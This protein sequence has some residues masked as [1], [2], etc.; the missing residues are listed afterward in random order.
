MVHI[1]ILKVGGS[2]LQTVGQNLPKK[3]LLKSAEDMR[4]LEMG[5]KH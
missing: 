5:E 1:P 4:V 3:M 2:V